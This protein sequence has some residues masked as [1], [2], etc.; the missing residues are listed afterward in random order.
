[1]HTGIMKVDPDDQQLCNE[2][3]TEIYED[4]K[5][6]SEYNLTATVARAQSPAT[7]GLCFR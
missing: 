6:L 7:V 5:P 3:G 1:M 2:R 4:N